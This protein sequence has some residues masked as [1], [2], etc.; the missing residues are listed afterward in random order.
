MGAAGGDADFGG[1]GRLVPCPPLSQELCE[2][3]EEVTRSWR[4]SFLGLC[5]GSNAGSQPYAAPPHE[6]D[7]SSRAGFQ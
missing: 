2:S 4:F 1:P 3:R 6:K 5:R 7:W